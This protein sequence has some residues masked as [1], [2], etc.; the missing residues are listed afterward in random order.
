MQD[1]Y[2]GAALGQGCVHQ[3]RCVLDI[4]DAASLSAVASQDDHIPVFGAPHF[5]STGSRMIRMRRARQP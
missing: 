3:P 2:E 5:V 4:Y 1:R